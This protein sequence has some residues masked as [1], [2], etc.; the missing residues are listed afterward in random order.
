[1]ELLSNHYAENK[2][3][4]VF[5]SLLKSAKE[6]NILSAYYDTDFIKKILKSVSEH[7]RKKCVLRFIFNGFAGGRLSAQVEE[8]KALK[9]HL[10]K[11]GFAEIYI[12]M[13]FQI[14]LFHSKVYHIVT[15]NEAHFFVGSSNFTQMGFKQNEE[16]MLH[17]SSNQKK[18]A[19]YINDVMD[20][21]EEIEDIVVS[22]QLPN[23]LLSFFRDGLLYFKPLS[24]LQTSYKNL[25]MPDDLKTKLQKRKP[26]RYAD[27]V[28]PFGPFNILKTSDELKQIVVDDSDEEAKRVNI[29][30]NSIET[31][32]GYWVP[33]AYSEDVDKRISEAGNKKRK[34]WKRI[35]Q[36]VGNN[37]AIISKGFS[38]YLEDLEYI[39]VEEKENWRPDA[40]YRSGF[41]KYLENFL[42]RVS[43]DK[44]LDRCSQALISTPMPEIW[45]NS[46]DFKDFLSSVFESLIYKK[47]SL[48]NKP[49][50]VAIFEKKLG[51]D[52][53]DEHR[54][55][56]R[57]LIK[58]LKNEPWKSS[59]W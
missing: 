56:E 2:P 31:N 34:Y 33:T 3:F 55:F 24:A 35:Q 49:K 18:I 52:L 13:N 11:L 30:S 28:N 23:S 39:L 26:P 15:R 42:K 10:N 9:K 57:M 54:E 36:A 40:Q 38:D 44:F 43:D 37:Q 5:E 6:I 59:D 16:L 51:C 29:A 8:L 50:I 14:T 32:L 19:H 53:P 45:N 25:E 41:E 17:F 58:T 4:E 47:N 21:S 22:E 27:N 20:D 12:L 7:S 48:Q 1:M 46:N